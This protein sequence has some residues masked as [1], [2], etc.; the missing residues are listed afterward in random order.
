MAP[1]SMQ[2]STL[3]KQVKNLNTFGMG[4]AS[5]LPMVARHVSTTRLRP[6]C[7]ASL[8][9][10]EETRRSGNYQAPVWNNDFIQSFSTDKYKD[11]KF[12]KKKEELIA[13]V[14]VLLNTKME[15]V[16][17]LELIED[18]RNLG[19]TY[20]FED[21]FKKI[22]TSIYNEHKG[23]KNEQVGDLYFTSLA[24][25]LLRLH[26]FDVSEDVFNFFKN[27]DGSDFKAS[28]GENTKDVLELY[29]AS[30][31]IRV[32]EVTLEQARVFSTKILE[33]KVEEGIKDE[34][35]L[36]W[37]Q[38]SLA[39]P[40]HW[41][42]QRLE[43]RWF[44]DAYK[45]RKDMNPIIFELGKIDFHIIQET[46][47]QEV[48]EVS[49]WWTNSNLAEKLPFVRDRIVE[50][51]FWALGLFEPHEY[52]YQRKMAAIIITFVTIIDDV[53][54]VY[55]TLDELQLFTDAIRKWDVESISTLPYYMQVCYLAVFTYASELAYD[56]LKDQGFN[57]ISYLQRSWLS[58]VEGFFQE[59][60][61]YYAGYTPTLAEYLENAKVSISSPT[62]ISQVYF[63]L[64]NST[65]RT[66]VENVY[67]YHNILYLSGMILR[68]ADDLGTTQFELKR[69][70]VQKAIQ[71]YMNDNNATE[72]EGT[73]HVKYLLREAWQ[74]MNSAMADPDCPLS[75]DL[76]FA[77]A[78]L[79]RAS[80][81]IY[82]DGDG[83]GVQHSEIHNQMGGLIFEPYV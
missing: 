63:T 45:A 24:F 21:E 29:E 80:Q 27:E 4:G 34:K 81:F 49:Q 48:Q 43:A 42:I 22:L 36:A 12:L 23:F 18:L 54:D 13:Q 33:K 55:G 16:K 66:V 38:H 5:K 56:I 76:V 60:K 58:L 28:L 77:A 1:L 32:G 65:E 67:G 20:Y 46:Q 50:C 53:Y 17:Q 9:V 7:S 57:S 47:L 83:H 14:K 25:R 35:L 59:A 62:I 11:E 6:I 78:N 41:R 30:F 31:L 51:Y 40:L 82:L 74:E 79:G 68:L 3:S 2:V 71:C 15:A 70:D 19:L 10:E 37:I 52:G 64:P 44:L 73:E 26:G 61:W 69:G 72:E 75:E 39:L 8:Q